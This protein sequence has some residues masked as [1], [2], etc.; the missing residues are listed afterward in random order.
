MRTIDLC[1]SELF[2][3]EARRW[4]IRWITWG[5]GSHGGWLRYPTL[6]DT[7][8]ICLAVQYSM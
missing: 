2:K 3:A 7:F 5:C 6:S 1:G 8:R 4:R